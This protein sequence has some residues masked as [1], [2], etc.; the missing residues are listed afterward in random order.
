MRLTDVWR[1]LKCAKLA[2]HCAANSCLH[3][4]WCSDGKSYFL[5]A[6]VCFSAGL[7]GLRS[8]QI[9]AVRGKR[10]WIKFAIMSDSTG[11]VRVELPGN[12]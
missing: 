9:C 6:V 12:V 1:Q 2:F 4:D 10:E 7:Q 3:A 5:W 8:V 11:Q